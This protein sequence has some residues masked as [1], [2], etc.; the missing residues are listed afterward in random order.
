[1][2]TFHDLLKTVLIRVWTQTSNEIVE[3]VQRT[4]FK[5]FL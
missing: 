4:F 3:N 5:P 2:F 1:M